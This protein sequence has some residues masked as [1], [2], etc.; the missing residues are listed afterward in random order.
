MIYNSFEGKNDLAFIELT[1]M[2]F[3]ALF[4]TW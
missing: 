4:I 3:E 2:A 1:T